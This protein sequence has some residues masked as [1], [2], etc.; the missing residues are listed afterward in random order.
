MVEAVA[1]AE[2][3]F[4]GFSPA[5]RAAAFEARLGPD[6]GALVTFAGLAR[7][8]SKDGHPLDAVFLEHHPVMTLRSLQEIA[9]SGARRFE[10]SAVEVVHRCGSIAPGEAIVWVAASSAHRRAAFEAADYLMDR[11]KTEA[12]FWK[13]EDGPGGSKWIEPT[14][15]DYAERGRWE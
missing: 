5:E 3:L 2:L 1:N 8:R 12:I 6:V 4:E 10:V 13:R 11:L 7:G 14:D 9:Q 15:A